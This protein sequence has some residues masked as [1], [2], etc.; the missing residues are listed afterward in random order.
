MTGMAVERLAGRGCPAAFDRGAEAEPRAAAR[1]PREARPRKIRDRKARA[2]KARARV[3]RPE[4]YARQ[5]TG[6]G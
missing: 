4:R 2:R 5:W 6:S 1:R 3:R